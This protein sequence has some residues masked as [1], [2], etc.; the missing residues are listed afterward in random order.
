[1]GG[2]QQTP[3]GSPPETD[4]ISGQGTSTGDG[5]RLVVALFAGILASVLVLTPS[6]A[7]RRR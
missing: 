5:W 1:V 6:R 4:T 2:G 7:T 3:L